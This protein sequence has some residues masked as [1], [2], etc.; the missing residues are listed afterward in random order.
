[1]ANND[2]QVITYEHTIMIG[3]PQ[4]VNRFKFTITNPDLLI[5]EMDKKIIAQATEIVRLKSFFK[6]SKIEFN[7]VLK[8]GISVGICPFSVN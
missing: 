2:Q 5:K 3:V 4:E 7:S 6:D 1:M 8:G